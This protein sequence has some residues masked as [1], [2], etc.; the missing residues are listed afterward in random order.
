MGVCECPYEGCGRSLS[1]RYNLKK[2]IEAHH[3]HIR[4]FKC[5]QCQRTFAY[6]HSL[7]HHYLLHLEIDWDLMQQSGTSAPITI[8]KLT[9]LL[10]S[11]EERKRG[12]I[13]EE[14]SCENSWLPEIGAGQPQDGPLPSFFK[15]IPY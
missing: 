9:E 8:P 4:P 5:A 11:W 12:E 1:T 7:R 14:Q 15:P 10:S 6:K 3:L 13:K 2:H